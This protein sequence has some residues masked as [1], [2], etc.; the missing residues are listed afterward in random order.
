[1]KSL[2]RRA[3]VLFLSSAS[4]LSGT[5]AVA[6]AAGPPLEWR[7][8]A[9]KPEVEC[10][11]LAV[12]IDYAKPDGETLGLAVSRRKATDPAKRIGVMLINPGGPGGSG[13]DMSF[14]APKDFSPE[15]LRRFDVIGFDPRGVARSRA[16][17][18]SREMLGKEP[19]RHPANAAEFD[20]YVAYNKDL[21]EDCRRRTGPVFDHASTAEVARDIE[22]IRRALGEKKISYYGVS[23]GT[24]IGQHYAERY[25]DR[26]RAMV[27]DSNMDHSAGTRQFVESSARTAQD[28]LMEWVKWNDRTPSSPLHGQDAGKVWEDLLAKA[29]RGEL[30]DPAAPSGNLSKDKLAEK[31]VSMAY[32][33]DWKKFTAEVIWLRDGAP[34]AARTAGTTENAFAGI[35]C[36]DYDL[37]VRSYREYNTLVDL[38]TR[39]APRVPGSVLGHGAMMTCLGFPPA[40]NPQRDLKIRNAPKI[41]LTN[42]V[43]DPATPYSWAENA[44]RQSRDSTVFVAYE[45][46]GHGVYSASPCGRAITD[47]YL[48]ELS[49]PADGTRCP[50]FESPDTASGKAQA[51]PWAVRGWGRV[52][53]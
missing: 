6:N 21:R 28:S 52:S 18:C 31:A 48:L 9:E 13:V 41:L 20:R 29:A 27:I 33:P 49:L 1:M 2:V 34:T 8:C 4:L 15:L 50:A 30:P 36:N 25:G 42:A 24:I 19:T 10:A 40:S 45:G 7:P 5:A 23:Y 17:V 47:R 3:V 11:T 37:R 22:E 44:H 46:W 43:H 12:P 32:G 38:E 51:G 53:I 16:I 26:I 35:F 39:V 14:D